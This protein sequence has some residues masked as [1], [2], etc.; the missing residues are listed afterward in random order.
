MTSTGYGDYVPITV[1]GRIL[2]VLLM[3]GGLAIVGVAT[4][5]II[6]YLTERIAA[7]TGTSTSSK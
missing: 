4:A 3:F 5:T 7:R 2:A 1:H 6:S